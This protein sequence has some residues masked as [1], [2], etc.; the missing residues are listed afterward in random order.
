R[1][2]RDMA[3]VVFG[4]AGGQHACAVAR[5]LGIRTILC[6]RRAGVLSAWGMGLADVTWHGEADAG[7][8]LLD[9]ELLAALEPG[10]AALEARGA[11]A[12]AEEGARPDRIRRQ[13]HLR[14]RGS[15]TALAVDAAG[16]LEQALCAAH[17]RLFGYARPGHPI[18]ATVIRVEMA[19][20]AAAAAAAATA[21]A[22]ATAAG[23]ADGP[24]PRRMHRLFV[25]GA[26]VECPIYGREDLPAGCRMAGPAMVL[27]DTST[28]VVDPGFELE[29]GT[30]GLL[31]V[32]DVSGPASIA[33]SSSKDAD[34][35]LLEIYGNLF[36]S[37]ASQMGAVLQRTALS[38]NIRERLDY[39]CAVF[40]AGGGLVANAPHIP[41]H[42]GA[43]SESVRAILA[44]HPDPPPGSAFATNDPSAGGSHLPD[45]T[46]VAPVHDE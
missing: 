8:R 36:M 39:S 6:D 38:T 3:L 18:E 1:D 41:V 9:P 20:R 12:L 35:V 34:P 32:R 16:D 17:E 29:M 25:D 40:D 43:M 22:T 31:V 23:T 19:A 10:F 11:A 15:D 26:W 46:V 5:S 44:A 14:Y 21:A 33:A 24:A 30:D 45:I 4:G 42:L 13:V 37:I 28:T 2:P 7:R 27:D